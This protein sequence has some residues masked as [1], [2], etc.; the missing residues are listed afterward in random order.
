V[1]LASLLSTPAW[2]QTIGIR[3]SVKF[4]LD[5]DGNPPHG[6]WTDPA[7]WEDAVDIANGLHERLGRGFRYLGPDFDGEVSGASQY[8]I[9]VEDRR[10]T[11][12]HGG[13]DGAGA[14]ADS[15]DC[16]N[17]PPC[18]SGEADCAGTCVD[19]LRR[20]ANGH[21]G[22]DGTGRCL[23]HSD[24]DDD[25][26]CSSGEADCD[27]YCL[28]EGDWLEIDARNNPAQFH[29]RDD[30]IN[31]Y[32][33]AIAS[34]TELSPICNGWAQSPISAPAVNGHDRGIVV[35]CANA[36]PVGAAAHELG[37]YF[38]LKHPWDH[39]TPFGDLVPDTPIDA[40]PGADCP[41]DPY[42]FQWYTACIDDGNE[43]SCCC[44]EANTRAKAL[45]EGWA[46]E[47]LDI[48]L[49]NLMSYHCTED[50]E[51]D[52][53]EGQ[54]DWYSSNARYNRAGV[55]TGVT[56]FVGGE[57]LRLPPDAVGTYT[58]YT[59]VAAGIGAANPRG[60]DIVLIRPG[61]YGET[62]VF[63][64]AVTL[65]APRAGLVTIGN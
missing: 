57:W 30:A 8:H 65:R 62:G 15:D 2:A 32:V 23:S 17:D 48:M 20:C 39:R 50:D 26:P 64:K 6:G 21:G 51:L 59:T 4:I 28:G 58:A 29:W 1:A 46:P 7:Q 36:G 44:K 63:Y 45:V 40:D 47:M 18:E 35:L 33:V 41:T 34:G 38:S 54:I 25:P 5:E 13:L 52:L 49:N 31:I 22:I 12:G 55:C 11:N 27:R 3:L 37:H 53:S 61:V 19:S 16:D 14:C 10:C 60:G 9:I 43:R 24:C 42:W 56:Y